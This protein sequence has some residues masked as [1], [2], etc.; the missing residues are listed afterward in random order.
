MSSVSA[1]EIWQREASR[2]KLAHCQYPSV[3]FC[4]KIVALKTIISLFKTHKK[5]MKGKEAIAGAP[6]ALIRNGGFYS[7]GGWIIAKQ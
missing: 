7:R 5:C 2:E 6:E 3:C 4:T 1:E